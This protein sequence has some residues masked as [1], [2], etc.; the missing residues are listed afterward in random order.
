M[1]LEYII[2]VLGRLIWGFTVIIRDVVEGGTFIRMEL[3]MMGIGRMGIRKEWAAISMGMEFIWASVIWGSDM[4]REFIYSKMD[5]AMKVTGSKGREKAGECISTQM[6]VSTLESI[7]EGS[8][9]DQACMSIIIKRFTRA[10]GK[11][12][13]RMGMV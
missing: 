13:R 12:I 8:E 2:T 6:V 3:Y 11:K 10:T 9:K 7:K 1:D 4:G 5:L